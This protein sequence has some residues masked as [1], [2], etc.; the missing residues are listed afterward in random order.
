MGRSMKAYRL[1]GW[2]QTPQLV[3][4]EVPRPGPGQALVKVAGN[5]LCHSDLGMLHIPAQMGEQLGWRAP[6]TLGHEVGGWIEEVGSGVAGLGK[7]DPVALISFSSDGT[8]P[9]CVRG[10]Q[11]ACASGGVGRGYGRDGGLAQYVVADARE[12][13]KLKT[14]DPIA[15]GPLTDAGATSYHAVKRILPKL[16]PGSTAVVI[17]AGGLG[18][19]ALQFLRIMSAA[20]VIAVDN[21]ED[22]LTF[23]RELGAHEAL[24]G[25]DADT[26]AR[27]RELT[28]GQGAT[29]VLDFV[30]I[31]ATIEAGVAALR[32]A[33]AYALVGAGMGGSSRPWMQFLPQDGEVFTFQGSTIADTQEVIALAEAGLIRNEVEL[34]P[35]NRVA[36][37]YEKLHHGQLRGRAV[38]M[39]NQFE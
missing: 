2:E 32:K 38:V 23:A 8:C 1:L 13:I 35:F 34:F 31:D 5:G 17:G 9:Y 4:V 30:G 6:F 20:R 37:A 36:E 7:G 33:G 14:L 29:A 10:M 22:R 21:N 16:I 18:S 25:V 3:E 24:I 19:F 39:P 27:L 28:Q 12:V 15:A 11:N 26:T